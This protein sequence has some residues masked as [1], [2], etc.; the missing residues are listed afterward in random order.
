MREVEIE[1]ER[2]FR[3]LQDM[4]TEQ[5][6]LAEAKDFRIKE[7]E[8]TVADLNHKHKV[9]RSQTS[10]HPPTHLLAFYSLY[11]VSRQVFTGMEQSRPTTDLVPKS[12]NSELEEAQLLN[13]QMWAL[14][15]LQI[16][17]FEAAVNQIPNPAE[18][19]K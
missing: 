2:N 12:I 4:M 9:V 18:K 6:E 17:D 19:K 1:K 11:D 13:L 16:K 10:M 14:V 15:E 8:K 7:L 3:V 5:A